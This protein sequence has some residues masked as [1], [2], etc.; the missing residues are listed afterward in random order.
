MSIGKI[1]IRRAQ[2][3]FDKWFNQD[4]GKIFD[5]RNREIV[6]R[7]KGIQHSCG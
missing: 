3:M 2:V 5:R 6:E 7:L 4:I 1:R